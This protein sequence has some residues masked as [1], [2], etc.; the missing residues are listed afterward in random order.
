MIEQ[1]ITAIN[2]YLL[3]HPYW[4]ELF[5][6]IVAFAESL[7]LVGTV[8]PGSITMTV[9]GILVGRGII[10]GAT[11]LFWATLGAL[12]GDTIGFW[13]GKYYNHRLR[14]IWPFKK[15]PKW[16]MKGELFF[17]KHGGK[18]IVIGRFV[19]PVRSTVP[20]IAGLLKLSW[21]R[22]FMAAVPSAFLWAIAYLL[23]GI[24]IGAISLELAP[25][26]TTKFMIAG[27]AV[28]IFIWLIFWAIQR[29]FIFLAI[30]INNAIDKLWSWLSK[31]RASRYLIRVITNHKNP[32]D[33][34]QLTLTILATLS[35]ILFL[36]LFFN[37]MDQGLLTAANKPIFY[38]L[39][40][41]RT[42]H[43]DH[44]FVA[45]T[46]LG[47]YIVM[48]SISVIIAL[49]L[50]WKK[51]WRTC[52]HLLALCIIIGL[53]VHFFRWIF[54]SPRPSGFV[55]VK[56]SSSFPSGHVALA[57]SILGFI[58]F[59]TAQQ[60]ARKWH[61]IPY[62]I[63]ASIITIIAISRIY[64]GSHWLTDILGSTFL[65]FTILLAVV[66]SYRRYPPKPFANKYTP[67]FLI[68]AILVPWITYAGIKFKPTLHDRQILEPTQ[69]ISIESWWNDPTKYLPIYRSNRFGNPI[70]PFNLQWADNLRTIKR[71]LLHQGWILIHNEA[72]I[73][74]TLGRFSSLKP[75][76]H[77]P[78]FPLL[79]LHRPSIL[80]MIK[81]VSQ[82]S[83]ILEL[84]LWKT[85]T[86]FTDSQ[87]SL[88][89]GS[90]DYHMASRHYPLL[91]LKKAELI[92]LKKGGGIKEL[93]K[94]L[95]NY[96]LKKIQINTETEP[97][98]IKA[99]NWDGMILIIRP[100]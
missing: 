9:I 68:F 61:W 23:P 93:V 92:T 83:T 70:Q 17:Q 88:W 30:T 72:K 15:Y 48:Y 26:E 35:L 28:I 87:L 65:G 8:I 7:P 86:I 36:V 55:L 59:L 47:K 49:G 11:T 52:A 96:Q 54:Y 39:Q 74:N 91:T 64:L 89:I 78:V 27:L 34:H 33:H 75:E 12:A 81:H 84:R 42:T 13:V 44:F 3:A 4:G 82:N 5:A 66:I 94:S 99:L 67:F 45:M 79:Y 40:S 25:S 77:L 100:K 73:K 50:I 58:A 56:A 1:Y 97:E 60:L 53:S 90:V 10:P 76:K 41:I 2:H 24:L 32:S 29:F 43:T 95:N 19:G 18:S 69:Y 20:L 16:L 85:S 46:M 38:L 62:T 98:K 71:S 57:L 51:Q 63:A 6:F 22:F 80:F 21:A 31:H 14:N 37:I